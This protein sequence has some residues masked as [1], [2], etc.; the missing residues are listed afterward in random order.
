VRVPAILL[1]A[2]ILFAPA[3]AGAEGAA[4]EVPPH[5]VPEKA[6][7]LADRGRAFH[8]AGD[9]TSAIAAFTQ[10]YAMAPRPALLFNLAQAYRLRGNCDD[11]ALMYRRYLATAPDPQGRALAEAHLGA[12]ERC[13]H[14]VA[15]RIA[16]AP[17]PATTSLV[18]PP[19]PDALEVTRTAPPRS[20]AAKIEK[21]VGVGLT[22][23]GSV[24]LAVAAYYAVQAH[25]AANDVTAAYDRHAMWKDIAPID[26][27][28]KRAA[29][30]A[31]RF[32]AGGALGVLGGVVMYV[33]GKHTEHPPV[34]VMPTGHG[35]EVGMSWAF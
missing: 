4:R 3:A 27:R 2:T 11:A 17:E 16:S 13:G 15:P 20:S 22:V 23:A 32:G 7:A 19:A 18:I 29:T 26:A 28:G 33:I 14:P 34:S 25:D 24:A 12:V 6:R 21:G 10:A 31:Q 1:A 35:V 8:D 30:T 9:Y 5:P